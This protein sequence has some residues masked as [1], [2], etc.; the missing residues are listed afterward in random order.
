V[1]TRGSVRVIYL[2]KDPSKNFHVILLFIYIFLSVF[3]PLIYPFIFSLIYFL[4]RA[5]T[6][7]ISILEF[8]VS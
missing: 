6:Y 1:G 8:L 5:L 4:S 2:S 7:F 3:I